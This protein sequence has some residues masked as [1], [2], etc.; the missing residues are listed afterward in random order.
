MMAI[1]SNADSL[2]G[3]PGAKELGRMQIS[4]TRWCGSQMSGPFWKGRPR[5]AGVP[6]LD[7]DIQKNKTLLHAVPLEGPDLS[8]STNRS[9]LYLSIWLVRLYQSNHL[10]LSQCWRC[11]NAQGTWCSHSSIRPI[12]IIA[13]GQ[14]SQSFQPLPLNRVCLKIGYKKRSI[15]IFIRSLHWQ[16]HILYYF[17]IVSPL[18]TLKIATAACPC[19]SGPPASQPGSL[20][21]WIACVPRITWCVLI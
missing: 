9:S 17:I 16:C 3:G 11:W 14:R 19:C 21:H 6:K 13:K 7:A 12:D 2:A 4:L 20:P 5:R 18:E 8:L 10:H 1:I 15:I